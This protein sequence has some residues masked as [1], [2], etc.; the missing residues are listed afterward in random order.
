MKFQRYRA[1]QLPWP[2]KR[3]A[4]TTTLPKN[5]Y[6]RS[7]PLHS[8]KVSTWDYAKVRKLIRDPAKLRKFDEMLK[9]NTSTKPYESLNDMKYEEAEPSKLPLEN[10]LQLI[11][12]DLVEKTSKEQAKQ[13]GKLFTTYEAKKHRQRFILWPKRVNDLLGYESDFTLPSL[14]H[15]LSQIGGIEFAATFD[16]TASYYQCALAERP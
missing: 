2:G 15:Q 6:E 16:F 9:Y 11:G 10:I 4:R 1:D 14:P 13:Y 12:H 8:K 5:E 3:T 7:S